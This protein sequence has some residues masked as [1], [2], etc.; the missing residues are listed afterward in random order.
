MSPQLIFFDIYVSIL[1]LEKLRS[2]INATVLWKQFKLKIIHSAC[3]LKTKR[4]GNTRKTEGTNGSRTTSRQGFKPKGLK[5]ENYT[6]Q[7]PQII[8]FSSVKRCF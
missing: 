3:S 7:A 5:A 6:L 1:V 8:I 2:I 4:T